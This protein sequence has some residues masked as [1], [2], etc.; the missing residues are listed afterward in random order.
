MTSEE[1]EISKQILAELK[2]A[3]K[4]LEDVKQLIEAYA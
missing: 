4:K 3:N 1:L 2:T